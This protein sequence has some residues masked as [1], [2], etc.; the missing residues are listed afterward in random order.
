MLTHTEEGDRIPWPR[1][2]EEH[3]GV[4]RAFGYAASGNLV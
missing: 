4:P 3:L 2:D 1:L